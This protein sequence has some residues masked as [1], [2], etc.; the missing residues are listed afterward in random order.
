TGVVHR[1]VL[2]PEG[3]S[4]AW[5][6]RATLWNAVE[7]SEKRKDAQVAREVEVALPRELS[8]AEGISLARDFA[9]RE[10]VARGMVADVCIHWPIGADSDAKPHVHIL[11]TTRRV[12]AGQDGMAGCFGAKVR[13]WN[14]TELLVGWRERWAGLVNAR[15]AEQGHEVRIDHRRLAAQ[16]IPL[17]PQHKVGPAGQRRAE[18]GEA[19]ER[20]AEH[21]AIARRN[22]ARIAA[23]PMVAL[24]AITR[25]QSTFTWQELARFVARHTDGA[26]QFGQVLA[27]VE[28]APEL[29]RLGQDERGRDR[30]T[31]REMLAVEQRLE[32]AGAV[33]ARSGAHRVERVVA[34]RVVRAA[35]VRG[36]RLSDEQG[37][38]LRHVTGGGDLALVVGYAG[39][40][41]SAMLG[42]A[43]EAWEAAGYWVRGAAL[44]GIAAEGLEAGSGI[45]SR[46]LASLEW[47][48][49]RG[50]KEDR[51]TARDVLV[52]DE[53][54]M[55]G[56]RQLERVLGQAQAAGAKVVLVGDPEQLQAIE[57]G[58]AFR[59]LAERH[60]AA[61]I[62]EVRRQR[63]DWQR[64]ATRELATGRTAE[65]I[66]RYE[67]AGMVQGHA[68]QEEARAA[69]VARWAAGYQ[70]SPKS[71]LIMLA[72]TRT[73]VAALNQL[74]RESL[75]AGGE[76]GAEQQV[77]TENGPRAMAAGDRIMFLRNERA[78]GAG[79]DGRGG[80]AV[81][82]G[83]LGTVLA[84][85]AGGERLTVAL[86][87]AGGAAGQG[88]T[89]T[90]SSGDY[91]YLDHGYA[92]TVHKAQ[93]VT[94]DRAHVLAGPGMDQH[95]AYVALTRHREGVALHWSAEAM[96]DRAGLVRALSRA[97]AKDTSLDYSGPE[98]VTA[99]AERRGLHP[100]APASEIAVPRPEER[101][102]PLL[103]AYRDPWGRDSLGRGTT[104]GE[105]AAA[106]AQDPTVQHAEHHLTIWI[107]HSYR[108]PAEAQR[109]LH[110]LE[111]AEGGPQGVERALRYGRP[112][113]LGEL[114]G[115]VGWF[116]SAAAKA[117]RDAAA[118][119][120]GS[121]GPGL[122][123]LREAE[124]RAGGAYTRS[125][126]AQRVRDAVEIPG[127]SVEAWAAVRAVEAAARQGTEG[128][129]TA[130]QGA[131]YW[132]R[133]AGVDE[134]VGTAWAREIG[135]RPAVAAELAAVTAAAERR[136]GG[137]GLTRLRRGGRELH[138]GE[139]SLA[140]V[141]G[142]ESQG[143]IAY[144]GRE[145]AAERQREAEQKRLGLR[146]G[147]GMRM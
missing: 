116:A 36:M 29:V 114:R 144:V 5:Q 119:S 58:A 133:Q 27:K 147:R 100:L 75:H 87:G 37:D 93:G 12:E 109:R 10:F 65:A 7:A 69:L 8:P 125:V 107:G 43:R 72:P 64:E 47:G 67:D 59:A 97:R 124:E 46:T 19:A 11:L 26:E 9:A 131:E 126:E 127:L 136:F 106:V 113:L 81:K 145:H 91:G 38:A 120:A 54:G 33:L 49:A 55:V 83:T 79:P 23:E 94:V 6:D 1:E 68:T 118:R 98:G 103:A 14:S 16:G 84:V 76:L 15:L 140:R 25:Q 60:G 139:E 115:K 122:V 57:A 143:L 61:E 52:V 101:P 142:V 22:G 104:A 20:R 130:T 66:G 92:A 129:P 85:E 70:Q 135:R 21:D 117:E 39:T 88:A 73:D 132:A 137:D 28:T 110:A 90:F 141:V 30:F 13:E 121:I 50:R 45:R 112:E 44:S 40:G 17:E 108:D 102:A 134:Q 89:V 71:S 34:D 56:S 123:Q 35:E 48:W 4:E 77:A 111:A 41:K 32:A 128:R 105:V 31:T 78:L 86:D 74:A 2:L 138:S 80:A 42:V 62:S 95:M 63:E 82:N 96:G 51:L 18:R 53:A 99:F 146:Q 3:A 24:D